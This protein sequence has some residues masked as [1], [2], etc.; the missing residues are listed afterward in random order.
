MKRG[1][2]RGW[3]ER[4]GQERIGWGE[5]RRIERLERGMDGRG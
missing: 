4:D 3:R 1:G 5:E 2:L